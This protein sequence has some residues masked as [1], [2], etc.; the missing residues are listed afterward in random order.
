MHKLLRLPSVQS[1][2]GLSR[3]TLYRQVANRLWTRP[4]RISARA[5]TEIRVLVTKL[6]AARTACALHSLQHL[7]SPAH[8]YTDRVNARPRRGAT[9]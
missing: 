9:P 7:H 4:I 2:S 8:D 1:Q 6:E 3:S 5:E